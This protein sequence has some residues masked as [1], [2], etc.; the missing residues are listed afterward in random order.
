MID[1]IV[2][3]TEKIFCKAIKS[4][5]K[6]AL[7][8]DTQVSFIMSLYEVDGENVVKYELCHEHIPVRETNIK[9]LLGVKN[10]DFKGYTYFV[11]P[12]IKQILEDFSISLNSKNIEISVYLSRDNEDKVR[13]FL[14]KDTEYVKEFML[15]DVL[16]IENEQT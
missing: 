1:F 5:S 15:G 16:K 13:Y 6:K 2:S 8:D 4:F 11:P 14:Y 3:E 12:R 10:I 7:L 9:E